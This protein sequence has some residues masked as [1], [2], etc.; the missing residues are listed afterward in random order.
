[1]ACPNCCI[2]VVCLRSV[3]LLDCI[4]ECPFAGVSLFVKLRWCV[5]VGVYV[6]VCRRRV[7]AGFYLRCSGH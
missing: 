7:F 1:M 3:S 5:F 6:L 2:F 4:C